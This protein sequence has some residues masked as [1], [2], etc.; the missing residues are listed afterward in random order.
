MIT[1]MTKAW[2][3]ELLWSEEELTKKSKMKNEGAGLL[4]LGIG[5]LALGVLN[6]LLLH[7]IYESDMIWIAVTAGCVLL[8]VILTGFGVKLINKTGASVAEMTAKDSGYSTEE[9]LEFYRECR[10]ADSLLLSLTP[11]PTKE[12][13][14]LNVGFLTKNW[15]R[16]PN[17]LYHG[18][19]RISDMA[20]I[21][22]EE[23]AL[24]GYDPGIFV[25]KSD[26]NML[27]VKCKPDIGTELVEAFT[28]RNPKSITARRFRVE[29]NDYDAFKNPQQAADL[30]RKHF[31]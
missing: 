21:W 1:S 15:L 5:I 19:M 13:D 4:I 27:Y 17:R 31:S 24:P 25:V 11:Q 2:E 9:I 6:H 3:K 28:G 16:L 30:Y 14:F 10:Q 8:G 20:V 29:G 26:G 23:S 12:K 22:Y 18:V 7:I